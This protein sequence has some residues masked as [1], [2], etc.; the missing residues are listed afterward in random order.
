MAAVGT[1]HLYK[2]VEL[3]GDGVDP[4]SRCMG[5]I[6]EPHLLTHE[7]KM[8]HVTSKITG[9]VDTASADIL[10]KVPASTHPHF[11]RTRTN[12]GAGDV[13]IISYEGSTVSADGTP[14]S[15][16]NTNRNSILT[17]VTEIYSAPTVT[18]LGTEI[19]TLWIP[20]T[21]VGI[22]QSQIGLAGAEAGEEW[23]LKP[24]TNYIH[25]VT[26]E[27]GSTISVWFEFL[28]YEF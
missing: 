24:N 6:S 21:G 17:P 13:D 2:K 19:H 15:V 26:N 4:Y 27:S 8:F 9:L 12:V 10:I 16:H 23:I 7:G 1:D 25:R 14:L 11:Q 3:A 5:S 18:G 20:P 28:F 22:G